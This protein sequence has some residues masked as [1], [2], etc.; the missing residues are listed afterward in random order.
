MSEHQTMK[1][2]LTVKYELK[3]LHVI[4]KFLVRILAVKSFS[5]Y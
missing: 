4:Y 5:L 1:E 2:G 3:N